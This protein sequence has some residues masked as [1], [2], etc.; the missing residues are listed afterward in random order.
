M[1]SALAPPED[2]YAVLQVSIKASQEDIRSAY[3]RLTLQY[4]GNIGGN[5]QREDELTALKEAFEILNDEDRRYVYDLQRSVSMTKVKVSGPY[6]LELWKKI[7]TN[8]KNL[9]HQL[10]QKEDTSINTQGEWYHLPQ[11]PPV[12]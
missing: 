8:A 3:D 1:L 2:H 7:D 12:A 6:N 9:N 4:S 5:P 10:W 11:T